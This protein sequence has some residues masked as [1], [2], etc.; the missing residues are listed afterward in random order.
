MFSNNF[1]IADTN[2]IV[3]LVTKFWFNDYPKLNGDLMATAN[4]AT[5]IA[6]ILADGAYLRGIWGKITADPAYR[7]I[8]W[9]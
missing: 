5:L 9:D 6:I 2:T 3:I 4:H 7:P 1:Q 8:Q